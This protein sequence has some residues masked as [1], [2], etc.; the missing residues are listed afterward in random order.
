M[1]GEAD[2]RQNIG[3]IGP[4]VDADPAGIRDDCLHWR[5]PMHDHLPERQGMVEERLTDPHQV[6]GRLGVQGHAGSGSRMAEEVI[7]E[8]YRYHLPGEQA[9]VMHGQG[10]A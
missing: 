7:P 3:S 6:V 10:L 8:A 4:G 9:A 5:V 2:G 1:A